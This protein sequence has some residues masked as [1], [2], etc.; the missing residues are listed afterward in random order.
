MKCISWNQKHVKNPFIHQHLY[1]PEVFTCCHFFFVVL[2][3]KQTLW[4]LMKLPYVLCV[5]SLTP[6]FSWSV[7]AEAWDFLPPRSWRAGVTQ[8]SRGYSWQDMGPRCSASLRVF[9]MYCAASIIKSRSLSS[10]NL[11]G[12]TRYPA[13]ALS[14]T[15]SQIGFASF[16]WSDKLSVF[17]TKVTT[18]GTVL[19]GKHN[20][21][22]L[23]QPVWLCLPLRTE[24]NRRL[25]LRDSTKDSPCCE[26]H[27]CRA[28][29][30]V[31]LCNSNMQ[32]RNILAGT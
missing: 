19:N 9:S 20:Q 23:S 25:V 5:C 22:P 16:G 24:C 2:L 14:L 17:Y 27:L 1:F 3:M 26:V 6:S 31:V 12:F 4:K 15:W 18:F 21:I 8:L 30:S 11:L 10:N 28:P 32:I 29:H 7:R 13:S